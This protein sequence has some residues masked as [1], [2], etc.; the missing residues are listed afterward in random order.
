MFLNRYDEI[1]SLKSLLDLN[2]ASI[3]VCKGRRRIGKSR[4]IEEFSRHAANF[5]NIQGLA[6]RKGIKKQDQ[7]ATFGSQLS[8]NTS[9]PALV[10]DSWAQAF[11]LLNSVIGKSKTVDWARALSFRKLGIPSRLGNYHGVPIWKLGV[12]Q[13]SI[14]MWVYW[15]QHVRNKE[16]L[17]I[18]SEK[19]TTATRLPDRPFNWNPVYALCLRNQIPQ[20]DWEISNF[21]RFPKNTASCFSGPLHSAAHTHLC[22]WAGS[23][24]KGLRFLLRNYQFR[25]AVNDSCG[26]LMSVVGH[27]AGHSA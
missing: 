13:H 24:H 26:S 12:K 2:K 17:P 5:I 11:S 4:L 23:G 18:F 22:G 25:A 27:R 20:K 3:A 21:W 8:K 6:P 10:P 15:D 9:L 16:C 1:K 19:N 14:C 7:L